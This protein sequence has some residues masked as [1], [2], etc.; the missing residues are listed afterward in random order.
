MRASARTL[1]LRLPLL[2]G[3]PSAHADSLERAIAVAL[4]LAVRTRGQIQ[5]RDGAVALLP[6]SAAAQ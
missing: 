1:S 5:A 6:A 3:A 4:P 2:A